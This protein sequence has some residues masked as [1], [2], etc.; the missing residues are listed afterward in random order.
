MILHAL[1]RRRAPVVIPVA[2]LKSW[3]WLP[4]ANA[5]HTIKTR[6]AVLTANHARAVLA[7]AILQGGGL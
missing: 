3:L 2:M 5:P 6:I 1:L 7:R 4:A